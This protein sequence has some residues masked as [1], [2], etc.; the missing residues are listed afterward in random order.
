MAPRRGIRLQG[1]DSVIV[2]AGR[3]GE[4]S[5]NGPMA[6]ACD[7]CG[8]ASEELGDDPRKN[9]KRVCPECWAELRHGKIPPLERITSRQAN[10]P[11]GMS[12]VRR[13][14]T[15]GAGEGNDYFGNHT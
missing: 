10:V 14:R 2:S 4:G 6:A 1:F 7:L 5:E 3:N 9:G 11:A 12:I 13:Q 8:D 15:P